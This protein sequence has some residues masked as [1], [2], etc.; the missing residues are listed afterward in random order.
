[1]GMAQDQKSD[2]YFIMPE[3]IGDRLDY[4]LYHPR[5]DKIKQ[6]I[7]SDEFIELRSVI[8]QD[9]MQY[10]LTASGKDEGQ[11][12]FVNIENLELTG[13][14][15]RIN[16]R[17]VDEAPPDRLLRQGDILFSRSRLVGVSTVVNADCINATFGSYIIRFR[18]NESLIRP[19]YLVKLINS[20]LGQTQIEYLQTGSSGSNIN[21]DQIKKIKVRFPSLA[22]QDRILKEI[23]SVE[24]EAYDIEN[25]IEGMKETTNR[26]ILDELGLS[27]EIEVGRTRYFFKT[28]KDERSPYFV[29]PFEK[30]TNRLNYTFYDPKSDLLEELQRRYSTTTLDSICRELKRGEQPEYD[31]NGKTIVIKTVDLK[32]AYIDYESCLHVA[33]EFF[34]HFPQ[35]HIEQNDVL[36]SSTGYVSMGKIEMF[37]SDKKA[38][39]DAHVTILRLKD[40]YDPHFIAYF[41]RSPLGKVQFEKWWTGSSGQIELQPDDLRKFV[42]I[43]NTAKG[44]P[45]AK[46]KS[47]ADK[48]TKSISKIFTLED[49]RKQLMGKA[50]D[51]FERLS[52]INY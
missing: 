31:S 17:Y 38:V 42:V 12:P 50:K 49:Q 6:I 29:I 47:I 4:V 14:I 28:G 41:L 26:I 18:A 46:Q 19:L 51:E 37:D 36:V 33:D 7:R 10:G 20:K 43:D 40:G 52:Q 15:N 44:A 22:E 8:E 11:T 24:N 3:R 9:S 30:L 25:N 34:E 48:I 16:I 13:R 2:Y 21:T 5:F 39:A 27:T 45:I 23:I 1:M 35:A 32:D